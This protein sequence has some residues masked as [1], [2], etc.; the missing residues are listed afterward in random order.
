MAK[1]I[2]SISGGRVT[3]AKCLHGK[4]SSQWPR[5]DPASFCLDSP[6][7][8]TLLHHVNSHPG[9]LLVSITAGISPLPSN[10]PCRVTRFHVNR[11]LVFLYKHCTVFSG[12][13][14]MA[15]G[16]MPTS[17]PG[18]FL[19]GSKDPGRR[20][21][22]DLLKSSRFLINYLGFLYDNHTKYKW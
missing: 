10:S 2:H 13:L 16:H 20:W 14:A 4:Y 21:S 12:K 11:P 5:R 9:L 18:S 22:R 7:W 17:Y 3:R 6:R 1:H 8:V 19:L 15:T